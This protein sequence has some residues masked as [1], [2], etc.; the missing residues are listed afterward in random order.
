MLLNS[1]VISLSD[2]HQRRNHITK[3]FSDLNLTF[4]FYDAIDTHKIDEFINKNSIK[5]S[6][7]HLS[8]GEIACYLSHFDLWQQV[9]DKNLEYIAIFEDDIYLAKDASALLTELNWLPKNF[10]A[11]KLETMNERVFIHKTIELVNNRYLAKM[12]SRHMGGAGYIVSRKGAS[13]LISKTFTDGI[14]APVDHLIFDWLI[15]NEKQVFQLTPAICIQDKVYNVNNSIFN[16]CLE[17]KRSQRLQRP[18]PKGHQKFKR[19]LKRLKTHL[20]TNEL[21]IDV[22]LKAKGYRKEVIRYEP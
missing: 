19:E 1:Y 12:Q 10:D 17:E 14:T 6:S 21:M 8:E 9:V 13:K 20:T 5:L 2:K 11:I 7:S 22:Y 18:K 16:S 15:H 3:I 4:Y